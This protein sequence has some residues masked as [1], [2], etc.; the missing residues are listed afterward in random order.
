MRAALGIAYTIS[1]SA[2][3]R[4]YNPAP[5]AILM[6]DGRQQAGQ[7]SKRALYRTRRS[8]IKTADVGGHEDN[9]GLRVN[10]KFL[11][12]EKLPP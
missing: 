6:G 2:A 8:A 11:L 10:V 9:L 7:I 1:E 3:I 12:P 5:C 4:W